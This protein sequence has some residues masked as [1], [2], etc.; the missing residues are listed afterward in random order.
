MDPRDQEKPDYTTKMARGDIYKLAKYAVKLLDMI[1]EDHQLEP[2]QVQKITK[3][4]D[5]I[6]SVYHRLDYD[7]MAREAIE[8]GPRQYNESQQQQINQILHEAW[9]QYKSQ[10]Q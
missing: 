2:W 5:Y 6:S 4:S 8:S 10:G 7:Q 3:A 9:K 1:D